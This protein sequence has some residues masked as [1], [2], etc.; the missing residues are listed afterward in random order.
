MS[1]AQQLASV[2]LVVAAVG[3]SAS[4]QTRTATASVAVSVRILPRGSVG[5][6][7]DTAR[8]RAELSI[9]PARLRGQAGGEIEVHFAGAGVPVVVRAVP[10]DGAPR[11]AAG[12]YRGRATL[13]LAPSRY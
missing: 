9:A 2:I 8:A 5:D 6:V 4:A 1:S 10:A 13:V 3:S 11:A 12:V 7:R